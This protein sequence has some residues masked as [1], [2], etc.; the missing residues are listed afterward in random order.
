MLVTIAWYLFWGGAL[1]ILIII[2]RKI[3]FLRSIPWQYLENRETFLGFVSRKIHEIPEL[4]SYFTHATLSFIEK[5]LH[6]AKILALRLH[7]VFDGWRTSVR[8]KKN[9]TNGTDPS[10]GIEHTTE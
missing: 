2:G 7:N 1:S 6:R 10:S 8:A 9:G 5:N 3:P 4:P